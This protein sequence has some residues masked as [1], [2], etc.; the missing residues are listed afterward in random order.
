MT[1]LSIMIA[2][3]AALALGNATHSG[4][5]TVQPSLSRDSISQEKVNTVEPPAEEQAGGGE[6]GFP[7]F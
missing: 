3:L 6:G 5:N 4:V 7:G 1:Q 2:L